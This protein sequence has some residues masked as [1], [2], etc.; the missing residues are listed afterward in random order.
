MKAKKVMATFWVLLLILSLVM[1][2]KTSGASPNSDL[3]VTPWAKT[4]GGRNGEGA[5][6]VAVAP[7]GDIIVAGVTNSFGAGSYDFWVLRLDSNG[8]VKWQKT[9]GGS[10]VDM[11]FAVA[12]AGNGD[13]IVAGVTNSFGAGNADIW[14][15]RL[16]SE[17]N[18][19]WQ[20]TYGGSDIDI[21]TAVAVA[22]NG[23]IIVAGV[24]NSFGAGDGDF[25][26][27]R[28]DE[29]GNVKWQ[30]TYGG[31]DDD[32]AAAVAIAGNGDIIVAGGTD[33]FGA[34]NADIWVLRL[35][36]EGK[37]KWQKTYGGRGDD[38]A[39]AVAIA[40]SGDIIVA[41]VT[42]SF[43][44]GDGDF[45]VLRLDSNGN[46]KWQKT[47]G[48]RRDNEARTVVVTPNGDIIVAGVANS[49]STGSDDAWVLRLDSKGNI[50]WQKTY[51]G[52]R[53][54][55]TNKV[56]IA[57]NGDVIMA[58]YTKSFGTGY[59]DAWVLR[60]PPDGNL[61]GCDFCNDSNAQVSVPSP[62][63][64]DTN[65]SVGDTNAQVQD[66]NA[67]V[68]TANLQVHTYYG[69]AVLTVNSSPSG[70]SVYINGTYEGIT[71]LALNLTPGTYEVKLT[72]QDY[73]NYTTTV[74][75]NPLESKTLNLSLTPTFGYLTVTSS[76]S[77]A[78]VIIDGK[79]V[80]STPLEK[81]RLS[82]GQHQ[83]AIRKEG[84]REENFTLMIEAGKELKKNVELTPIQ[85]AT[86]TANSSVTGVS[87]T[88]SSPTTTSQTTS[89]STATAASSAGSTTT[90]TTSSPGKT[91]TTTKG[92]RGICG[93]AAIIGLATT[94][95][96]LRRRKPSEF[97]PL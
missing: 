87:S 71:P 35:D 41:G 95:L 18:V 42:N 20:K 70:A 19:K 8:N 89:S 30:K 76:P 53:D 62:T 74:T 64:K 44:A 60:L 91:P 38:V 33:S 29:N 65:A 85:T 4:Y 2:S 24:T 79:E 11:A 86:A 59:W 34:G 28:L 55:G 67:I 80:G 6:A 49:F 83:I 63:V 90:T 32:I 73:Q 9:Y 69:P 26:V 72:K 57:P 17:G 51:G 93:P 61:P 46:V 39:N 21:A 45:W 52:S 58:G 82:T 48:G 94:P 77:G 10:D 5:R 12:I 47:Y 43:G 16:D 3:T 15:L 66:S 25:W 31:G 27:L 1:A 96:L 68:Q 40:E 88:L 14:V 7:N 84:Y 54:D 97:L 81:Y 36:S 78:T 13:I 50:K 75:L 37:V 23:D 22:P 56:S 92:K